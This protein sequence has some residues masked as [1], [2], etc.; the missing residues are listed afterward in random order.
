ML[1]NEFI[2][3]V[4][5][6]LDFSD[7]VWLM[8]IKFI[9]HGIVYYLNASHAYPATVP[10]LREPCSSSFSVIFI[11]YVQASLP[12]N[13]ANKSAK[14]KQFRVRFSRHGMSKASFLGMLE[15]P[16]G[17]FSHSVHFQGFLGFLLTES[18]S[19]V[20]WWISMNNPNELIENLVKPQMRVFRKCLCVFYTLSVSVLYDLS[21]K[22]W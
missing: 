8:I 2:Y 17:P 7:Q 14:I 13:A 20:Y 11:F 9:S 3:S 18:I 6:K 4:R 5:S 21:P 16:G 22:D 10:L 1:D 19:R 12:R 15:A